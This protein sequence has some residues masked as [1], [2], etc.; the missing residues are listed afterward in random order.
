M[1][2]KRS[3][4]RAFTLIELL[5]VIAI[6]AI[7][8]ALLLPALSRAKDSAHSTV[9]LSN[10]RQMTMAMN[11]FVDAHG[12]YP[13]G[14]QAS[15]AGVRSW[16]DDIEAC[17]SARWPEDN[18]V[19]KE[20][21]RGLFVCPS[22]NRVAGYYWKVNRSNP[23]YAPVGSY[24]YNFYGVSGYPI[25]SQGSRPVG[26]SPL[27]LGGE[28]HGP[29]ISGARHLDIRAVKDNQVRVPSD[30]IAFGDSLLAQVLLNE[31]LAGRD[32]L[33]AAPTSVP[34]QQLLSSQPSAGLWRD[35][36]LPPVKA[37]LRR[38]GGRV[39]TGFCDG[40]V[41]QRRLTN[42][43]NP[44]DPNVARRWNNDNLPHRERVPSNW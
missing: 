15:G 1:K 7:L 29:I 13:V 2:S 23:D 16:V 19:R 28:W 27:G 22:Y 14:L 25:S 44:L 39:L 30:M 36:A 11:L 37:M 8:A 9:C 43:F 5:V 35:V 3:Q 6:I 32:D 41:E 18:T 21:R 4:Q 26:A 33:S 38:H 31:R 40:H 12:V 34:M 24:G 42:V 17:A 20:A 10:L